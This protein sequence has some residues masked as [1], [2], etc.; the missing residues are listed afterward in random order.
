MH[1][2]HVMRVLCVLHT[3]CTITSCGATLGDLWLVALVPCCALCKPPTITDCSIDATKV[4][5]RAAYP[6]CSLVSAGHDPARCIW[7]LPPVVEEEA[8]LSSPELLSRRYILLRWQWGHRLNN[9]DLVRA[10]SV[11]IDH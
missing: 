6:A 3:V 1:V 7:C 8:V 5:D 10:S 9:H 4:G 2:L 11:D